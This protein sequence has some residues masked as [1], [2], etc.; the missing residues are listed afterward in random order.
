MSAAQRTAVVTGDIE[1]ADWLAV[2]SLLA[3]LALGS[4]S[5]RATAVQ[6][7]GGR[8]LAFLPQETL[9]LDLD[10]ALQREF[11]DYELVERL[12]Q[13]G[14]GVVY[15]AYQPALDREV[16][17][18][19]RVAGP[20]ASPEF[21][22]R[23][24]GV[25]QSAAR[26]QHPN[27]VSIHEVG[28]HEELN[29][30]SMQLV[31]GESLAGLLARE[32]RLAPARA[33][34]LVRTVAEAVDYAHRLGVLH[35][36]LKP[37]NV[38]LDERGEPLVAD[39]GLAR[40][41][42][43]S[44]AADSDEVSGTPSYMA[45]EQ[46][47][48]RGRKL[49]P[50]TDVYGL[51]AILYELLTGMPPFV[52]TSPQETLQHVVSGG[53]V[54]PR[55]R[56]PGIPLD[57]DAI[58]RRCLAK[59]PAERYATARALADDLSAFLEGRQVSVLPLN[60]AQRLARWARRQPLQAALASLLIASF[61]AGFLATSVQWRRAERNA[62]TSSAMLWESRRQ[63]AL[64]L[65]QEGRGFDALGR[66][67][68]N[69]EEEEKAG[70]SLL[71]AA[72]RRRFG[73]IA[74]QSVVL[75][76]RVVVDDASPT[77]AE[78]SPDGAT[79]AVAFDDLSV[80]WYDSA[81]LDERGRVDLYGRPT[82]E[83][84]Q[85]FHRVP[86]L[87]RFVDNRRLRVTLEWYDF[88]IRPTERDT[89]L[90][91]LARGAV[92]DPPAEFGD[93]SDTAFSADG[94]HAVLRNPKGEAQ[95]WQ[96]E[97]W[98]PLSPRWQE[99][100]PPTPQILGYGARFAATLRTAMGEAEVFDPRAPGGPRRVIELRDRSGMSAWAESSDGSTV[101]LGDFKG[102]VF[103]AD[104]D[105]WKL[106]Q[107]AVPPGEEVTWLS[108][109]EDDAWLAVARVD[110]MAYVIEVDTGNLLSTSEMRHNHPLQRVGVSR[111]Q[112]LLIAAGNGRTA[113]W[114]LPWPRPVARNAQRLATSPTP[115]PGAGPHAIC[116]SLATG[117]LATAGVDGEIRLW[118]LPRPSRLQGRGPTVVAESL[119][120]DGKRT[121]D[122]AY[123]R[124][125]IVT[126][127]GAPATE[128]IEL[129]QP[130]T[131]AELVDAGRTIIVVTGR[132][133]RVYDAATLRLRQPA[134]AISGAPQHLLA[135]DDGSLVVL[136]FGDDGTQGLEERIEAWDLAGGGRLAGTAVRTGPLQLAFSPDHARLLATGPRAT[137]TTVFDLPAL[138]LVGTY[139]HDPD[140][141]VAWARFDLVGRN[142][143]IAERAMDPV[144]SDDA[145]VTWDPVASAIVER[146]VVAGMGPVGV[147]PTRRGAFLVGTR[148]S[149]FDPR[150]PRERLIERGESDVPMGV[151]ALSA[152]GR[153][154]ANVSS[155]DEVT[156]YDVATGASLGAPLARDRDGSELIVQL[157]FDPAGERLLGLG[158]RGR[159]L[160][161]DIGAETRAV[162]DLRR[163]LAE[164]STRGPGEAAA[165]A[166][167]PQLRGE[168]RRADI[169]AW[170]TP[171]VRPEPEAARWIGA[172]A[173]PKRSP[174]A[175]ELMLDLTPVANLAPESVMHPRE[176]MT[177]GLVNMPRGVQ[178]IDGIDYDLR[179]A[180]Q[181]IG[182]ATPGGALP[183]KVE[184]IRG[185]P[186]SIAA[187]HVLIMAGHRSTEPEER[188]YARL[189]LNYAD[190]T[191]AVLPIRTQR[192]VP[193]WTENDKPVPRAWDFALHLRISGLPTL[194][195]LH[196]PRLPNPHPE[197]EI[198]TIDLESG[199]ET[200][201]AA[202]FVA[203]TA[204]PVIAAGTSCT[205]C[206]E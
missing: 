143:V 83:P 39:F 117:L 152:D 113:L 104:V 179:G 161:W 7:T 173:V 78:F 91:D 23:F 19:L 160:A 38:L 144:I 127:D 44:L 190:G 16:A 97:P 175:S 99:E 6:H 111:R 31:R 33:A 194:M 100:L 48:A 102:R 65:E 124:L 191:E 109:S 77:A 195:P 172:A 139:A 55:A 170:R 193:G 25:A 204:E 136:T 21:I 41:L 17:I 133:L 199:D 132:E 205:G 141:Y 108:F 128:W 15:R 131:Y 10:D 154:L 125:R 51:G 146:R 70:E 180:V 183:R 94:A 86:A 95:L 45:P 200:W 80:R 76:D 112:Q 103:V 71:V 158:T 201:N 176:N 134:I 42:D 118:R 164:L 174:A 79:L 50:A 116:W 62:T 163:M 14:M 40:R 8:H 153:V 60:L 69:I 198:A 47:T 54:P 149:A 157:A 22:D 61:V 202:L 156:L 196:D 122:V 43:E 137:Q 4:G 110:G 53:L 84:V 12:G 129:P 27:I 56:A 81:T 68:L 155:Y 1:S 29:Y 3:D 184:G 101:A 130:P 171:E 165:A 37:G 123:D 187:F 159:R 49:T 189:R 5:V 142:L 150:G 188:T 36:D 73:L 34:A 186:G 58:C 135:R 74:K 92:V 46:A 96:V 148:H 121:V 119:Y 147:L 138:G 93:L 28:A 120:F 59:D 63:E 13:G 20:W 67:L 52:G 203:I 177:I 66:L 107:V 85:G 57:L 167:T 26:M 98:R 162:P 88:W 206:T 114:R 166:P 90:V 87:L 197:R 32:Q 2:Q 9:E 140:T 75:I 126:L 105:T 106:E 178:R 151:L 72:D 168:L 82:S 64:R 115:S 185:P 11:G 18:K 169:G 24:R 89:Y 182:T 192:D 145:L 35:L 181:L 30:F